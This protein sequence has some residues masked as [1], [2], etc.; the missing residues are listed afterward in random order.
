[1][2]S[3]ITTMFGSAIPCSRAATFGL[4]PTMPRC[5]SRSD[6]VA[7]DHKAGS[8]ANA[9]LKFS[10]SFRRVHSADQLQP[11]PNR[12]LGIVLMR[13]GIAEID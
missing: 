1:V 3:V 10:A 11:R 2:L 8:D 12:T 7:N 5:R 9:D 13:L 4:S 6:E